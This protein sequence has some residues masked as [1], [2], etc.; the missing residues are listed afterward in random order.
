MGVAVFFVVLFI[1]GVMMMIRRKKSASPLPPPP[2]V[3]VVMP[4]Q[5]TANDSVSVGTEPVSASASAPT[6][7]IAEEQEET[8]PPAPSARPRLAKLGFIALL[9]ITLIGVP[10]SIYVVTTQKTQTAPKAV[11]SDT[12]ALSCNNGLVS[13]QV[14]AVENQQCPLI[15]SPERRNP[16]SPYSTTYNIT[17]TSPDRQTHTVTFAKR[18]YFCNQGYGEP[19]PNQPGQTYCA[20]N[21]QIV[22]E[23]KTI[24]PGETVQVAIDRPFPNSC[25][26]IQLD[27]DIKK[28]DT[29]ES[30]QFPGL[31]DR[32]VGFGYCQT[33]TDC[34]VPTLTPTVTVPVDEP[35]VTPTITPTATPNP[36]QC[37]NVKLY[38]EE[39]ALVAP[40]DMTQF[41]AG[42]T[43][44]IAVV[45]KNDL[46]VSKGRIRVKAG[47]TFSD[48]TETTDTKPG[49]TNVN[50]KEFYIDYTFP[51][52]IENFAVEA[53]VFDNGVWR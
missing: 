6:A 46:L 27:L 17:N 38:D 4:N 3:R 5:Y 23:T 19:V 20:S 26:S 41:T 53:E 24:A 34:Q 39:W 12:N 45:G 15:S 33:G 35:T 44:Y 22:E 8:L 14:E 28:V 10:A 52:Q 42:D 31:Y 43:I 36:N 21:E 49:D 13:F 30:C 51:P 40:E 47:T 1:G 2:T 7:P 11:D 16:F 50:T 32:L 37:L 48:W 18:S 29:I 9:M 25:G